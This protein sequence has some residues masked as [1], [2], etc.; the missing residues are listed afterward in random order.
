[1]EEAARGTSSRALDSLYERLHRYP[2][3]RRTSVE[4]DQTLASKELI[5]RLTL[6]DAAAL[7]IDAKKVRYSLVSQLPDATEKAIAAAGAV[8]VATI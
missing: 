5:E 4:A 3:D 6:D 7:G 1:M 2:P 8:A